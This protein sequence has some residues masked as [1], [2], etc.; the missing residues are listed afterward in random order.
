MAKDFAK[1]L[2]RR[3]AI[4]KDKVHVSVISYSEH[5]TLMPK[6]SDNYNESLIETILDRHFYEGSSTSTGRALKVLNLD[7]FNEMKGGART[8][9]SG[10]QC[11]QIVYKNCKTGNISCLLL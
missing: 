11:F 3:F 4:S 7:V 10:K 9:E 8:K 2:C 5:I 1:K 6:F